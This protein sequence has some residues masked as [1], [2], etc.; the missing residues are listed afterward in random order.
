MI[1]LHQYALSAEDVSSQRRT[2]YIACITT[3]S[4]QT[5]SHRHSNKANAVEE[6]DQAGV[7]S[8]DWTRL[9]ELACMY[10]RSAQNILCLHQYELS[11]EDVLSQRRNPKQL[12]LA[13]RMQL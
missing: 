6:L 3:S 1:C 4:A 2:A 11:A 5:V 10:T 13:L 12:V 8:H 7:T 9:P